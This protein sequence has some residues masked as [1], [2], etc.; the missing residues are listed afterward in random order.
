ME[1]TTCA[2]V[3]IA[4]PMTLSPTATLADA[5][6][7]IHNSGVRYLPVVDDQHRFVGVFSSLSVL[8]MLLPSSLQINMGRQPRDLNFMR[9]SVEELRE[10]FAEFANDPVTDYLITDEVVL[11]SPD[12]SITEAIYLI[13]RHHTH[14]VSCEPESQRFLGIIT[15]NGLFDEICA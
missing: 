5:F 10:R 13:T 15:I 6:E 8:R 4:N 12:S 9:Q 2:E 1:K 3:M 11:A 7:L 14:V